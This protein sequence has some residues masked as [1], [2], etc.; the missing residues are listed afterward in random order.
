ME[1]IVQKAFMN[2]ADWVKPGQPLTVAD[3][4][5]KELEANKL[6][7]RKGAADAVSAKPAST[8]RAQAGGTRG[9]AKAAAGKQG[10]TPANKQG[11]APETSPAGSASNQE[12]PQASSGDAPAVSNKGDGDGAADA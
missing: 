10:A 9:G 6:V 2:G 5:G 7:R 11:P 3:V 12:N 4:R 1:V 8:G